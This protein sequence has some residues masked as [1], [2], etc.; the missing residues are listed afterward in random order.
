MIKIRLEFSLKSKSQTGAQLQEHTGTLEL[1]DLPVDLKNPHLY[2]SDLPSATTTTQEH[3]PKSDMYIYPIHSFLSWKEFMS[4]HLHLI[5][6]NNLN[7]NWIARS[8]FA[9]A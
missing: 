2:L 8:D 7:L 5:F 6:F 9:F 3:S 4:A 1:V